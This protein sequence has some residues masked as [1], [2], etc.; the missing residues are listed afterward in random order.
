MKQHILFILSIFASISLAYAQ[1][2]KEVKYQNPFEQAG[3]KNVK[4]AT[5]SKG[6]Y[7]EF[8]DLDSIV[9]IGSTLIN[10]NSRKIVGFVTSRS[11]R[12]L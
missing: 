10:V 4:V 1:E 12:Y 11:L 8:H 5:L 6:K 7:Q 2:Q 3:Y 9:Q